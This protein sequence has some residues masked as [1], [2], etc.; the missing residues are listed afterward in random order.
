MVCNNCILFLLEKKGNWIP[1][2]CCQRLVLN[3]P[4][5]ITNLYP[6]KNLA[7]EACGVSQFGTVL[8]AFDGR[9][10]WVFSV[11]IEWFMQNCT[12]LFLFFGVDF[13]FVL[14]RENQLKFVVYT[15]A[16]DPDWFHGEIGSGFHLEER[17]IL[18]IISVTS[19][20][21][22]FEGISFYFR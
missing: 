2:G 16:S 13:S 8:G 18:Q 14:F 4:D 22:S 19:E 11:L 12:Y 6:A 21:M 17:L 15:S 5:F 1:L 3:G 10:I 9:K 7:I 20:T